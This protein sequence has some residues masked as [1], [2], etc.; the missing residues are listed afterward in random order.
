MSRE[1][2]KAALVRAMADHVL[3]E[4]LGGVSLR[5]LASAVGT[6]DRMLLYYFPDKPALI[7][8][9]L[10]EVAARMITLLEAVKA[11][12]PVPAE[13]LEARL[14]PMVLDPAV[15][16]F[17]QLWL[18][19]AAQAARGDEACARVG[20][21]IARG[22]VA[23]LE[24]QLDLA[25]ASSRSAAALRLLMTIEGGVLLKSLGLGEGIAAIA[26]PRGG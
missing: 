6:S 18:E 17:M 8:A 23:W 20:E 2:R 7:A 5:P 21:G 26:A 10:E 24:A 19:M 9:V 25:D 22:F 12:E 16:P 4:G 3:A 13:V 11:P 1:N 14:L 15:W